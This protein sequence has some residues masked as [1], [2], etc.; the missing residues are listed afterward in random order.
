MNIAPAVIALIMAMSINAAA[1]ECRSRPEDKTYWSWRLIDGRKCW[2]RG[3]ARIDKRQLQWAA[4]AQSKQ[5]DNVPFPR[6]RPSDEELLPMYW[7]SLDRDSN[8]FDER[9]K[10]E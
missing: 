1:L 9:F 8:T 10:G 5:P 2:Y 3:S 7:P 4:R 6:P